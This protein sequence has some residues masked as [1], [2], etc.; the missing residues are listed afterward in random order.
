MSHN[1]E[2]EILNYNFAPVGIQ[3]KKD[4]EHTD[5]PS[6]LECL[7]EYR[8]TGDSPLW[9]H[10]SIGVT[11]TNFVPNIRFPSISGKKSKPAK[12]G[13]NVSYSYYSQTIDAFLSHYYP[14]MKNAPLPTIVSE[15][16]VEAIENASSSSMSSQ[17]LFRY[18]VGEDSKSLQAAK[19]DMSDIQLHEYFTKRMLELE[20]L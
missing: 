11:K 2:T 5:L 19:K 15:K 9:Q 16:I 13:E 4:V 14:L 8:I 10:Y 3:H 18:T 7:K 17:C 12:I 20:N 6:L 1:I